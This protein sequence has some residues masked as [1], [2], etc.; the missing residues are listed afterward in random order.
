[1]V[2][3]KT[4]EKDKII[5]LRKATAS[6]SRRTKK[7]RDEEKQIL[8]KLELESESGSI[9]KWMYLKK[10]LLICRTRLPLNHDDCPFCVYYDKISVS[11]LQKCEN[12]NY[13][14]RHQ[15][16]Y[17]DGSSYDIISTAASDAREVIKLYYNPIIITFNSQKRRR[18]KLLEDKVNSLKESTLCIKK[19][20]KESHKRENE[21][22]KELRKFAK[23]GDLK[24]WMYT[25]EGLM[26]ER[27]QAPLGS[28]TCPFCVF[29]KYNIDEDTK[30][31]KNCRFG[32]VNGYCVSHGDEEENKSA[33]RKIYSAFSK[34]YDELMEYSGP[35]DDR[36]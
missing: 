23:D 7:T 22:L 32:E 25:K 36:F 15:R 13:R 28:D 20:I 16:C 10:E 6:V 35:N 21:K 18:K 26:L 8:F 30:N 24:N 9:H 29:H 1:M 5:A 33:Y 17:D 27:V 31:C 2:K 14:E 34:L 4:N 19:F 11:S 12:C 3:N